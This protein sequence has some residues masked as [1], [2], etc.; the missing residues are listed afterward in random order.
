MASGQTAKAVAG[1]REIL[2]DAHPDLF[3]RLADGLRAMGDSA[4]ASQL[5][6]RFL[7]AAGPPEREPLFGNTLALFL[8][9]RVDGG[10]DLDRALAIARREVARRPTTES[11]DLLSRVHYRRGELEQAL[12]YSNAARAWGA[13]SATMVWHR[14]VILAALG[15]HADASAL[16]AE[17]G[18]RPTLLAPHARA[19]RNRMDA[20]RLAVRGGTARPHIG[21]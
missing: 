2:S 8:V 15:R 13:P 18:A 19:E 9:E 11:L 12:E 6:A 7:A 4:G 10:R 17:A 5:E 14:G 16:L 21:P 1:Y 3:L 20:S